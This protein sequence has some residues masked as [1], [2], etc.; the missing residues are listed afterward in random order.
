[1]VS[2]SRKLYAFIFARGGSKGLPN[3]NILSFCGEPLIARSIKLAKKIKRIDKVIV[4]TDSEEI[5]RIALKYGAEVPFI[6]PA[7]LAEDDSPE[8]LS[9]QHALSFFRG[10][11]E[12]VPELFI[13]IP[14]TAPLRISDDI[15]RC[16]DAYEIGLADVI[17]TVTDPHR[18]PYFNMV[19]SKDDGSVDLVCNVDKKFHRR[20]DAPNVMDM[21]TV[22]YVSSSSFILSNNSIFDGVV[23]AVHIPTERAVDIDTEQDFKCAQMMADEKD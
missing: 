23:R 17:V 18:N 22:A 11:G 19:K 1:M 12:G 6:R 9:W 4:S 15:E 8:W 20:Q 5:A 21:T 16:I 13:S 2:N 3:K 7:H 10:S 14:A